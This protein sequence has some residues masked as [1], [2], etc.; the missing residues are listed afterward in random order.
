MSQDCDR[1]DLRETGD[2]VFECS[3]ELLQ[4]ILLNLGLYGLVDVV[5][6]LK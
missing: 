4:D 3:I 1:S 6:I 5:V 2:L